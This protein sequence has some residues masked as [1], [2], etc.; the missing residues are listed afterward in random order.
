MLG[1]RR[2][3][4]SARGRARDVRAHPYFGADQPFFAECP[5]N[6]LGRHS[7]DTELTRDRNDGRNARTRRVG[8]VSDPGAQDVGHLSPFGPRLVQLDAHMPD[9]R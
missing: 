9:R 8:S 1:V 6:L 4:Q 3:T 2:S 5:Q 7:S